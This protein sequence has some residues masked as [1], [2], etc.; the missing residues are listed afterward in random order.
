MNAKIVGAFGGL[1]D[2]DSEIADLGPG[3]VGGRD[4]QAER[5]NRR[6]VKGQGGRVQAKAHAIDFAVDLAAIDGLLAE[7]GEIQSLRHVRIERQECAAPRIFEDIPVIHLDDIGG[8]AAGCCDPGIDVAGV[9]GGGG[10]GR[11]G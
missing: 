5:F 11:A 6:L 10:A 9:A 1:A 8:V 3:H 2:L 7:I 4:P